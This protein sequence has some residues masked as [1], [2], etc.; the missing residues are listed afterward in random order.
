M[1][2]F[3]RRSKISDYKDRAPGVMGFL[4]ADSTVLRIVLFL[5]MSVVFFLFLKITERKVPQGLVPD[6]TEDTMRAPVHR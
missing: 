5:A 6:S 4:R 2:P 3:L 1:L